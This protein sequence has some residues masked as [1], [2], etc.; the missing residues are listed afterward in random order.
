MPTT[1]V[2]EIKKFSNT[3]LEDLCE[4]ADAAIQAGGGFG[5]LTPPPRHILEAY[6]KGVLV[7]PERRLFVGRLDRTIVGSAQLVRPPRNNEAQSQWAQMTTHFVAPYARG[8][9]LARAMLVAVETAA[10]AAGVGVLNLD[11]RDTQA[12]AIQLYLSLGYQHWGSHPHYARVEGK[13]LAGL[14]FFKELV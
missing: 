11:V 12:A 1:A 4:A 7:V 3:D 9:G 13:S 6:W 5:W 14:F 8:H 2:E 10:R